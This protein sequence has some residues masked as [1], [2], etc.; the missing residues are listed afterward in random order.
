MRAPILHTVRFITILGC[1]GSGLTACNT[2]KATV[3][4]TVKFF[5][6]T[7]PDSMFNQDGIVEEQHKLNLYTA[8]V[9]DNL[10]QDIARGQGEYLTSLGVLLEV[11]QERRA[12]W[13]Q[14]AQARYTALFPENV[15]PSEEAV[16]RLRKELTVNAG[17]KN[18]AE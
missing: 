1:L 15:Q 14:F 7:S 4:T 5:S 6:S 8:V 10:Q 13:D 12:E 18:L 2:T 3:D 16:A 17:T 9:H 11:P